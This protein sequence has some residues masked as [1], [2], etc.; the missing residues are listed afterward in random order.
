MYILTMYGDDST[1]MSPQ[2]QQILRDNDVI[3]QPNI[4][5]D[6]HVLGLIDMFT[7]TLKMNE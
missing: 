7:R 2:F 4:L 3:R 5:N 1:F 6:H